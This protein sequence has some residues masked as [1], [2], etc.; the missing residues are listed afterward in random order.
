MSNGTVAILG[1]GVGG[2]VAARYL[3]SQGFSPTIFEV[4]HDLGGQW[5]RHNPN[6]GVWPQMRTNTA[7]FVTKLSDVQYPDHIHLFPRNGEVMDM[8]NDFADT[9]GLRDICRFA[10]DV[11]GLRQV[12]GGY[13]VTW[14]GNGETRS[15]TFDRAV[16]S[17]GRYIKPDIPAIDGLDRFTGDCGV[18]HAFD[19]KS[20]QMYRDRNIVVLGGS[21]SS[22]EVASDQSMMGTG[23]IYLSQRRQRYVMP[24]MIAGTPLEYYAFTRE[25]G[26]ALGTT[27]VD[28]LLVATKTFL[29]TF[30]GNPARY[31]APA[32]HE[33]MAKAGVTGSQHF[34][35]LVA[36]DRIDVRPWVKKID[37][38]TVTF[39]DGSSVEADAIIIGTGFD[40]HLPFLSPEIAKTVNLTRKSLELAEFT[41]HPDLP[42]LAFIG[43]F[44]QLGPY[45]VVLEQQA[46]WIA[47]TW[48][49][50]IDAPT[51][52]ELRQGVADCVADDHHG[53][54]RQQHEMALRFGRLAHVDP[55][56]VDDPELLE[57]LAKSAV[58]GEM[59]RIVGLD[60]LPDAE[61]RLRRDF[62]TYG[63]PDVRRDIAARYG[64]DE[65]GLKAAAE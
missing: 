53:D 58:S 61:E 32:P 48:G 65:N 46:R 12:D 11:T 42:N 64:R 37:G 5:N 62:W 25:G 29:E 55:G 10:V 54:Y 6:S 40:L 14:T 21:I 18:T 16:V 24:K 49:G 2:L 41:F 33:D 19:Y 13:E 47:Y 30:G 36:E 28:E 63:P 43:L 8:I 26:L 38:T 20:P 51:E 22:L 9:F 34:L 50:A 60:A 31:G 39:D 35:N 27:P 56:G 7:H 45:P 1:A 15:E 44:A 23:R 59:F 17:T 52:A 3:K 57:I 4:H